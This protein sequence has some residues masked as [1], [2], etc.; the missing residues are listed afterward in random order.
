MIDTFAMAELLK[1]DYRK[2]FEQ[3]AL[4]GDMSEVPEPFTEDRILN[5]FDLQRFHLHKRYSNDVR[6]TPKA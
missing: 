4:Y 5:I 1:G 3:I 6:I 2:A